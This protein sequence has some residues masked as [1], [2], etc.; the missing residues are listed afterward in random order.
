MPPRPIRWGWRKPSGPCRHAGRRA[1]LRQDAAT[2]KAYRVHGNYIVA[3]RLVGQGL[4]GPQTG[5]LDKASEVPAYVGLAALG[6][7]EG[8]GGNPEPAAPWPPSVT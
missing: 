7:I 4:R 8:T 3:E 5:Y 1:L 2:A 6:G